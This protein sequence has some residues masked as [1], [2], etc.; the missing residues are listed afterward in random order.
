MSWALGESPLDVADVGAGTGL[1]T[2][3]LI[4]AGHR[5]VAV[6]PDR[7]M[8]DTLAASTSGVLDCRQGPA[9]NLPLP[10][11][12]FDAVAVGQAYHWFDPRRALPEIAR[13]L[14]PGGALIPI[15]NIRDEGVDWVRQLTRI[16]GASDAEITATMATRPGSFAPRFAD[17]RLR[18][19]RHE[20]PMIVDDLLRLVKSRSYYITADETRKRRLLDGV[21]ELA[22]THPALKG[23]DVF[24]MPYKVYV[25]RATPAQTG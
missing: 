20:K 12:S 8:L 19:F 21:R 3:A 24:A 22:A 4:A 9:E 11:G 18:I 13:V 23:R 6:E 15:W 5:V 16:I 17:P 7:Q 25:Y 2:R 10:D 14:R 1:L